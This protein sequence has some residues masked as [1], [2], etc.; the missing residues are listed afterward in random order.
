LDIIISTNS[1]YPDKE[2]RNMFETIGLPELLVI[3]A[4]VALLFGV[5]RISKVGKELGSAIS[6]F[7]QGL[8]EGKDSTG[9]TEEMVTEASAAP[10][11]STLDA[12][13][14]P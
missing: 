13:K 11:D 1:K 14:T 8:N 12:P 6:A 9:T 5:G 4:I 2:R 10:L 7:R 3:L